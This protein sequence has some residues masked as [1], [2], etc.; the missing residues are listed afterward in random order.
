MVDS[1]FHI[2]LAYAVVNPQQNVAVRTTYVSTTPNTYTPGPPT[3]SANNTGYSNQ[4]QPLQPCQQMP[5]HSNNVT[6]NE[7][8]SAPLKLI[9]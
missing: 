3:L 2:I 5:Q 7:S 1:F 4:Y 8:F 6:V 9:M